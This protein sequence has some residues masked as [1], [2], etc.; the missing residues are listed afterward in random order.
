MRNTGILPVAILSGLCLAALGC[1]GKTH[2]TVPDVADF[3]PAQGAV[4]STVTITGSHF[5]DIYSVS[6]GGQ[7]TVAFK[8]S[9][10]DSIAVTVPATAA[11]GP[12][13]VENPAGIGTNYT[14]F[15]V[16][17]QI[18]AV[19]ITGTPSYPYGLSQTS[20]AIGSS[21]TVT[22]YGLKDTTAVTIGGQSCP[23][24]TVVSA[25]MVVVTV[26][27]S[28]V[29]GPVALTVPGLDSTPLTAST[30]PQAFTITQ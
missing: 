20:G 18:C 23:V 27:P 21:F 29:T 8:V 17:P 15:V 5:N 26:G 12:L 11:T 19:A 1:A 16:T 4:G 3:S 14:S 30:D 2:Y 24:F 25:N 7:P 22:G 28:A 9:N 13:Y 10:N 6:F